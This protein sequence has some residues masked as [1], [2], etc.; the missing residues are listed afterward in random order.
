[1][2]QDVGNDLMAEEGP[3]WLHRPMAVAGT[4]PTKVATTGNPRRRTRC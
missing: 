2:A 4:G 1:M 3:N